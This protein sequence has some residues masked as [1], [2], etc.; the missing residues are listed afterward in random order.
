MADSKQF[1]YTTPIPVLDAAGNAVRPGFE[2]NVSAPA[3]NA[4][5]R[6]KLNAAFPQGGSRG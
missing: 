3:D 2:G 5:Q 4:A 6:T 1:V